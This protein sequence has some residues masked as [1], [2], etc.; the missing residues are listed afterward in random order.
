MGLFVTPDIIDWQYRQANIILRKYGHNYK[1]MRLLKEILMP[2]DKNTDIL[3]AWLMSLCGMGIDFDK[4]I[5]KKQTVRYR[6]DKNLR[7]DGTFEIKK[8]LIKE[9]AENV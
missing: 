1:V 7:E 4:V 8:V 5:E 9:L 3:D 2:Y 6:Y